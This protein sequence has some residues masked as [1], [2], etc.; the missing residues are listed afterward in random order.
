LI[1]AVIATAAFYGVANVTHG[2]YAFDRTIMVLALLFS[3]GIGMALAT[4]Q[5]A[6]RSKLVRLKRGLT[7]NSLMHMTAC[8]LRISRLTL[9]EHH[10][11]RPR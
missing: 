7:N 8:R 9:S 10:K 5:H 3:A 6:A 11:G 1:G 4:S 2:L